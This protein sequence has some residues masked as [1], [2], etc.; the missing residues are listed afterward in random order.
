M[1]VIDPG[2]VYALSWLDLY[3]DE[4]MPSEDLLVFVKREGKKYPGN[5]GHH[6]GTTTQEVLRA[7]IDRTK[8]VNN[9]IPDKRNKHIIDDLREAMFH[10]EARAAERHNRFLPI[11]FKIAEIENM[12]TCKQC[13]HIGCDG[14]CHT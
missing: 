10:L 8:Y 12:E 14:S 7:L 3:D 5:Q 11:H 9:Q 6:P 2:H 13:G 1:R 4:S